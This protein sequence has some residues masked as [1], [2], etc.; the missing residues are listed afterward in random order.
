MKRN[1]DI[2]LTRSRRFTFVWS[3]IQTIGA[4]GRKPSGSLPTIC[5]SW[6]RSTH[7]TTL[8]MAFFVGLAFTLLV[9]PSTS[10]QITSTFTRPI[11]ECDVA[12]SE[13]GVIFE[14]L[15]K[16]GS[17]VR[18]GELLGRLNDAALKESCRL[19]EL[20]AQSTA[21]VRAAESIKNLKKTQLDNMKELIEKGHGNQRELDQS[22]LQFDSAQADYESFVQQ[23]QEAQIEFERIKA[24]LEQRMIRSPI[25]GIVTKVHK[26]RGEYIAAADPIFCTVVSIEKL[27]T[28]FYLDVSTLE[29][30]RE[31][32]AA[33]LA[34]GSNGAKHAAKIVFRSPTID[35]K[36]STGRITCELDNPQETI[37]S[38]VRCVLLELNGITIDTATRLTSRKKHD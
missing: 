13:S 17:K 27:T 18:K 5:S 7:S 15:V 30:I 37:L 16:E 31:G 6:I 36:S 23:Q 24:E 33:T 26:S 29:R 8:P 14:I 1:I 4:V 3:A 12:A 34:I 20:R 21:K 38:G 19:A 10:A 11:E 28:D 2:D 22:Q 32:D 35:P 9:V 25:D